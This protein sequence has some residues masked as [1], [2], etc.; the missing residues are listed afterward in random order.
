MSAF[1]RC[2]ERR[3]ARALLLVALVAPVASAETRS[4]SQ[5]TCL[6]DSGDVVATDDAGE[7]ASLVGGGFD[8]EQLASRRSARDS[9]LRLASSLQEQGFFP[10]VMTHAVLR[11]DTELNPP[12]PVVLRDSGSRLGVAWQAAG[13]RAEL[14]AYPFDTDYVRVGYLHALDWG[15]TNV[16][17]AESVFVAQQGGAPGAELELA[18]PRARLGLAAKWARAATDGSGAPYCGAAST[19]SPSCGSRLGSAIFSVRHERR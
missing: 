9:R 16:E 17:Q 14:R 10:G 2:L 18:S 7:S 11:L 6:I 13:L 15:G 8:F 19:S 1:A 4:A 3:A 5:L 12:T